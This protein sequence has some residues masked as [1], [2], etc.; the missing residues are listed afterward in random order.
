M[1]DVVLDLELDGEGD[2]VRLSEAID[3]FLTM[4]TAHDS[5]DLDLMVRTVF[6]PGGERLKQLVFQQGELAHAFKCFWDSF[7]LGG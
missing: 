1:T 4:Q 6:G 5:F 3:S 7:R 2:D